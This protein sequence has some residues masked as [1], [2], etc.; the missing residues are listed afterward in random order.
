MLFF[1]GDII[2]G[3]GKAIVP[4]INTTVA[5]IVG[6]DLMAFYKQYAFWRGM[7]VPM[8]EMGT[9]VI[10]I[11]GNHE[12]QWKA[13]GKKVQAGLHLLLWFSDT[14]TSRFASS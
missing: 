2:M 5:G 13:G 7:M 8:M 11:P 4:T 14:S 10:L 1:N 3:Y 6:S 12:T 9:Y